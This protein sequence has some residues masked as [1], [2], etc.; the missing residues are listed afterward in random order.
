MKK[1]FI[2]L[3][4]LMYAIIISYVNCVNVY[5]GSMA[6]SNVETEVAETNSNVGGLLNWIQQFNLL[7]MSQEIIVGLVIAFICFVCAIIYNKVSVKVHQHDDPPLLPTEPENGTETSDEEKRFCQITIWSPVNV[8]VFLND[9][10]HLVMKV[11]LNSG[12][13]YKSNSITAGSEFT[14]IFS[15]KGF[16]KEI[17]FN[18][19]SDGRLEYHLH[20]VLSEDEIIASADRDEALKRIQA[21]PTGYAFRQLALAGEIEDIELLNNMLKKLSAGMS[22]K[23]QYRNYLI[24][25]CASAFGELCIKYSVYEQTDI[26][27][28]I[29]DKYPAKKNYGYYFENILDKLSGAID[30]N[31]EKNNREFL[32][33]AAEGDAQA[34]YEIAL[35]Y[36]DKTS[37]Y[38]NWNKAFSYFLQA[39]EGG[40]VKAMIR[41]ANLYYVGLGCGG[42]DTAKEQY[43]YRKAMEAGSGMAVYFLANAL[44]HGYLDHGRI[45]K[46]EEEAAEAILLYKRASESGI[47][48]A[49][50]VLAFKYL[51][52][53][54]DQEAEHWF[55]IGAKQGDAECQLYTARYLY[56]RD[57]GMSDSTLKEEAFQWYMQSAEQ[58]NTRAQYA[59]AR[60]LFYGVGT[61]KNVEKAFDM[62]LLAAQKGNSPAQKV[63]SI[64]FGRGLGTKQDLAKCEYWYRIANKL[65]TPEEYKKHFYDHLETLTESYPVFDENYD[66]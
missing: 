35:L 2:I 49:T 26:I 22:E 16:E 19:P 39:A 66:W 57:E 56:Y 32:E 29:Y 4:N 64:M 23:D 27:S 38:K 52:E 11:D 1:I 28:K 51:R 48:E 34:Q 12:F 36:A 24:A 30:E 65:E 10:K 18:M 33:K 7:D 14:L 40:N 43:W 25:C 9:K 50:K 42:K 45:G 31:F 53:H 58:G 15:A 5:A 20:A 17:A 44:D 59:A 62:I 47:L 41:V 13:E 46:T 61:E 6:L 63:L 21:D 8:D 54:N 3:I 55:L 60:C 37:V